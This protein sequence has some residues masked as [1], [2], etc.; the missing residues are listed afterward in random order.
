MLIQLLLVN[1]VTLK[2]NFSFASDCNTH[3]NF[4]ATFSEKRCVLELC[5]YGNSK[6]MAN[7]C[8]MV[9]PVHVMGADKVVKPENGLKQE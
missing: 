7:L 6:S 9:L 8:I 3:A 5:R 2:D 4:K 1:Q